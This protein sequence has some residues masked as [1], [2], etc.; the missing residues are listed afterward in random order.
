MMDHQRARGLLNDY[1]D[2]TLPADLAAS[3]ARHLDGCGGCR[4]ELAGLR[5]V[6]AAAASLEESIEP[7]RDLWPGLAAPIG[8]TAA[9]PRRAAAAAGRPG[10]LARLRDLLGP[11][12]PAWQGALATTAVA[13]VLVAGLLLRGA[14]DGKRLTRAGVEDLDLMPPAVVAALEAEC[15]TAAV[16][17]EREPPGA[18]PTGVAPEQYLLDQ[19][20]L[21]V[22]LA[23]AELREA[24]SAHPEDGQL[25]RML[26]SAYETKAA[27]HGQRERLAAVL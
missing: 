27:L 4:R 10:I 5:R 7:A 21:I 9:R 17:S 16:R 24:W 11:V 20:E 18:V 8:E 2:G 26:A 22:D 14:E 3:L 12:S 1:L 15:G 6:L 19:N 23:I 25:A 13:L